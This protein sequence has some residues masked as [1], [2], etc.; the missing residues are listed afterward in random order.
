MTTTENALARLLDEASIRDTV[1]RF[2]DAATRGD[3]DRFRATWADDARWTIGEHVHAT[4]LDDIVSTYQN[5]RQGRDFF[6]QFAVQGPI[7]ITGD[8]ATTSTICHEAARGP[9][10]TYYRNHCMSTDH[11]KRSE[12]GWVFTSRSFHYL[13]LDTTPFTGNAIPLPTGF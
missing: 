8:E 11:L 3:T 5:L 7:D 2:A 10:E 6:V 4:G 13:W 1:A 12:N 9:G